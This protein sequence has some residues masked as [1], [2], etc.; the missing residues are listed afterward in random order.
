MAVSLQPAGLTQPLASLV[1]RIVT[2][3]SPE[4]PGTDR[5]RIITA[6]AARRIVL[7]TSLG[8]F[9]AGNRRPGNYTK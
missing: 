9:T 2:E 5:G 3:S 4:S 1:K 7:I 6:A 8:I